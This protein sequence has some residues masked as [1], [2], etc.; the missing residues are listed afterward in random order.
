MALMAYIMPQLMGT[1][2]ST[3]YID[4]I[5][6]TFLLVMVFPLLNKVWQ[7]ANEYEKN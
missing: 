5:M 3:L 1:N 4:W 7:F 2:N 6:E